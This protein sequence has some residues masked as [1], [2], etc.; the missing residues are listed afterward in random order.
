MKIH[1][2]NPPERIT[3]GVISELSWET[4]RPYLRQAFVLYDSEVIEEI[5]PTGNGLR[6]KIGKRV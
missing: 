5:Q 4:L 3:S 1:I 6:I 2:G